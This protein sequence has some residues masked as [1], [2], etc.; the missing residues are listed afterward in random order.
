MAVL[1]GHV[2]V[3]GLLL[4]GGANLEKGIS[5]GW[6]PLFVAAWKGHVGVVSLLLAGGANKGATTSAAHLGVVAGSTPLAIATNKGHSAVVAAIH[7]SVG[8]TNKS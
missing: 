7:A 8:T 2:E 1:K 5:P 3:T 6:S 4:R